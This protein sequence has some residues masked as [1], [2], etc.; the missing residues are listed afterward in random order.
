MYELSRLCGN[1]NLI[2]NV[3]RNIRYGEIVVNSEVLDE[4][5]K[6]QTEGPEV[7]IQEVSVA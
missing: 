1:R 3:I 7:K 6:L 2:I 5:R 4:T